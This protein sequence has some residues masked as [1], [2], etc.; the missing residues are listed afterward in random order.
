MKLK[1][2]S[3][4]LFFNL[5]V[6]AFCNAQ[7]SVYWGKENKLEKGT[8]PRI[9]GKRGNNLLGYSELTKTK[10]C[11]ETFSSSDY[12][13]NGKTQITG[14]APK[15]L[16]TISNKDY[17]IGQFIV[18]KNKTYLSLSKYDKKADLHS[19]FAQEISGDGNLVGDIKKLGHIS[20]SN[21]RNIGDFDVYPSEDS[22]KLL[23]VVNPPYEKYNKEK[24]GF[25]IFDENLK[26]IHN[27]EIT[28]PYLDKYFSVSSYV[29]SKDGNIYALVSI[30]VKEDNKKSSKKG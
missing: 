10:L 21:K 6:F 9:L 28:L 13:S 25:K 27:L 30:E 5:M 20:A 23:M 18:L 12:S 26:Q 24:F 2:I 16:K 17:D 8:T 22:T 3:S 4:I 19:Y 29:L 1:K 7:V 11:T 14:K 15:G